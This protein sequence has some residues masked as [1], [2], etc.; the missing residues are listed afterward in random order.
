[1][2]MARAGDAA[3]SYEYIRKVEQEYGAFHHETD[4]RLT[5]LERDVLKIQVENS[6]TCNELRETRKEVLLAIANVNS[7]LDVHDLESHKRKWFFSIVG[8]V[9]PILLFLIAA[10][11][12][13]D[14]WKTY[15]APLYAGT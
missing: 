15:V 10:S 7:R 5:I 2:T 4:K 3:V 8:Y 9:T 6:D 13:Y 1:M 14:I 12:V 11:Q